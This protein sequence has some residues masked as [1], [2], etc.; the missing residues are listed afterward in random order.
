MQVVSSLSVQ[1]NTNGKSWKYSLFTEAQQA[2]K[3]K[4]FFPQTPFDALYIT[5]S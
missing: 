4:I 5:P 2:S 1:C 3:N